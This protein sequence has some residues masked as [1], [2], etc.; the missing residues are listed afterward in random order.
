[1]GEISSF[2]DHVNTLKKQIEEENIGSNNETESVGE[3]IKSIL[4]REGVPVL[5]ANEERKELFNTAW[6]S[7]DFADGKKSFTLNY[8]NGK[9]EV[10]EIYEFDPKEIG[11]ALENLEEIGLLQSAFEEAG[12]KLIEKD[13]FKIS[14]LKSEINKANRKIRSGEKVDPSIYK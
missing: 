11:V 12:I 14:E 10:S 5:T 3:K 1:M 8:V 4:S 6:I 13:S 2:Q 9:G 7:E